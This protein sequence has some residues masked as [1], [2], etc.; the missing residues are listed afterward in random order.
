M[1]RTTL[2]HLKNFYPYSDTLATA[3]QPAADDFRRIKEAGYNLI[4][5]LAL[6]DSPGA[7]AD[8]ETLVR[9]TGCDYLHIPVDFKTPTKEDLVNFFRAMEE[10]RD[11]SIFVHCAYN[12]RVSVFIYL[13]RT[14]QCGEDPNTAIRE[15]RAIWTPDSV[16]Q[17]FM[18]DMSKIF[19]K[20]VKAT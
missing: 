20:K 19:D 4:I 10:N 2:N 5:N 7:I 14:I 9:N 12:W 17:N 13:Y 3:G 18:D 1:T 16:W 15:L 6:P 11:K 8:E